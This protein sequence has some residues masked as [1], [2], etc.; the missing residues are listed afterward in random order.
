MCDEIKKLEE[1]INL[2][3]EEL[4]VIH[5][6]KPLRAIETDAKLIDMEDCF[7]RNNLRFEGIM[8]H[9]NKSWED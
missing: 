8:E 6:T 5:T 4:Q 9:K 7:R 3:K 2:R 1:K